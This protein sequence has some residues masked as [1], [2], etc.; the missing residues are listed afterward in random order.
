MR[1]PV[2]RE[3]P[4][5]PRRVEPP[6]PEHARE[7][8]AHVLLEGTEGRREQL[9]AAGAVLLARGKP[10]PAWRAHH[11]DDDRLL[12]PSRRL[13]ASDP[14]RQIEADRRVQGPRAVGLAYT[15]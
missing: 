3:S 11:L 10:G 2:H 5:V 12:R 14:H 15:Q 13:I 6:C 9:H 7:L 1:P 8:V 4:D